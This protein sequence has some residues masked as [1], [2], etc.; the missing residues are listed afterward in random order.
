MARLNIQA[1]AEGDVGRVE[2]TAFRLLDEV[3]SPS[4]MNAPP[5]CCGG[6]AAGW[7]RAVCSCLPRSFMRL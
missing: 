3:G 7:K 6:W 1:L 2:E 4:N 5:R